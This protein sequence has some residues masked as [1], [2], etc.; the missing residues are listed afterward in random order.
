VLEVGELERKLLLLGETV[1]GLRE[2]RGLSVGELSSATG[3]EEERI[4]ALEEGRLDADYDLLL[5][6]ADGI[7]VCSTAFYVGAERGGGSRHP[8]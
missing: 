8:T 5:T 3:V 4:V 1:R 2:Q 7:G 6:L